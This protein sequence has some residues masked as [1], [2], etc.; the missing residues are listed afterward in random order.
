M[1]CSV[2]LSAVIAD[3]P[4][5]PGAKDPEPVQALGRRRGR[6]LEA[7]AGAA[8]DDGTYRLL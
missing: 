7:I 2:R 1:F 5:V 6:F 4:R 8:P 3:E